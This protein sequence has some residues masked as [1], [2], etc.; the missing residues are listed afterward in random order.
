MCK[1]NKIENT[2]L[3]LTI[4]NKQKLTLILKFKCDKLKIEASLALKIKLFI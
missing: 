3:N 4:T 2:L 1:K